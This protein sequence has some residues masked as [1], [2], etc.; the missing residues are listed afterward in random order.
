MFVCRTSI[1]FQSS[2]YK[3]KKEIKVHAITLTD[4][5]VRSIKSNETSFPASKGVHAHSCIMGNQSK[6]AGN[7]KICIRIKKAICN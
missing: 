4:E 5:G 3:E 7:C 2:Q 1:S 6:M